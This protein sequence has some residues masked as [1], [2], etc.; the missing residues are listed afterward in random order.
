MCGA[1]L[2][3]GKN[4]IHIIV[5]PKLTFALTSVGTVSE[6]FSVM[7]NGDAVWQKGRERERELSLVFLSFLS[8]F[9]AWLVYLLEVAP[10]I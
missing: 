6:W 1:L 7:S 10:L 8:F 2:F 5:Y 3:V 4:E 9:F